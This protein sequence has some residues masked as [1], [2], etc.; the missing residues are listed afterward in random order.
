[1]MMHMPWVLATLMG[2]LVVLV[3]GALVAV[4]VLARNL[5]AFNVEPDQQSGRPRPPAVVD[6][7]SAPS[8]DVRQPT[9]LPWG[10][11]SGTK[12]NTLKLTCS[13]VGARKRC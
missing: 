10:R 6:A 7:R 5:A 4:R 9:C 1:M 8:M 3:L 2:F 13:T 11:V 12:M